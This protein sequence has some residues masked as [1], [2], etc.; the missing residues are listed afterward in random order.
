MGVYD[1]DTISLLRTVLDDAWLHLPT[2]RKSDVVKTEMAQR[3][4]KQA[5]NGVRD[6]DKLRAHALDGHISRAERTVAHRASRRA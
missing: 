2:N 6:P 3:I 1:P 4:L 5:A